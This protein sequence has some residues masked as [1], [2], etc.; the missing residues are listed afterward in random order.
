MRGKVVWVLTLVWCAF[1]VQCIVGAGSSGRRGVRLRLVAEYK[2][3]ILCDISS[4]GRL[5]LFYRSSY[6]TRS[7]R[8]YGG[9]VKANQPEVYDDELRVVDLRDGREVSRIRVEFFP[10]NEQLVPGTLKVFYKEPQRRGN[11]LRWVLRLWDFSTGEVEVCSSEDWANFRHATI[12]DS[13]HV[14]GALYREGSGEAIALLTLPDCKLAIGDPVNPSDPTRM[15]TGL[16]ISPNRRHLAYLTSGE[17]YIRDIATLRIIERLKVPVGLVYKCGPIYTPD[18][19]SLLVT[20]SNMIFD[21]AEAKHYLLFYDTVNYEAV[22]QLDITGW[23][24]PKM[25]DDS[26]IASCFVGTALAVSPDGWVMAVGYTRVRERLLW[27]EEQAEV[28][29]YDLSSGEEVGRVA[30]PAIRQRR[31]DPFAARVN[32]IAFTPD[33]KYMLTSTYDTRVWRIE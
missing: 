33:G 6:P 32:R 2:H 24:P 1:F 19:K 20:A 9:W 26:A 27:T 7:Y 10:E 23:M 14:F 8:I 12:V 17:V 22:R 3:D 4:D 25:S 31:D 5:V 30:H 11:E 13:Q 16:I 28:V 21:K 18:G 15:T 29:L